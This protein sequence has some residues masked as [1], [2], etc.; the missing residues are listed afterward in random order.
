MGGGGGGG[1]T[2]RN[3]LVSP[4]ALVWVTIANWSWIA[5][6]EFPWS[7]FWCKQDKMITIQD[8]LYRWDIFNQSILMHGWRYLVPH[9]ILNHY[10]IGSVHS[11]HCKCAYTHSLHWCCNP[12]MYCM[13]IRAVCTCIHV[14]VHCTYRI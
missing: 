13:F 4:T 5:C 11:V 2:G 7:R 6:R 12:S 3:R 14:H 10:F 1:V 8:T 9:P